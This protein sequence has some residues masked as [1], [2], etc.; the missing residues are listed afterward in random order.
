M[1]KYQ[2]LLGTILITQGAMASI[3][4]ISLKSCRLAQKSA[5]VIQNFH[6]NQGGGNNNPDSIQKHTH[7]F[8]I[9][10]YIRQESINNGSTISFVT[11]RDWTCIE[12]F[13]FAIKHDDIRRKMTLLTPQ[14]K[15]ISNPTELMYDSLYFNSLKDPF[16][17][18]SFFDIKEVKY[19]DD[20]NKVMINIHT[21]NPD[22][23]LPQK[24]LVTSVVNM[25]VLLN[26]QSVKLDEQFDRL[27]DNIIATQSNFH[28][29]I[30]TTDLLNEEIE[31]TMEY[32]DR[33]NTELKQEISKIKQEISEIKK[34]INL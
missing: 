13:R 32:I 10:T 11:T 16:F 8:R 24:T 30:I 33:I 31:S 14:K 1:K 17:L 9:P 3:E 22:F 7:G 34:A 15:V 29:K 18:A 6:I 25:G 19:P 2:Y 23:V 27:R 20:L 21:V 12:A 4:P 5:P 26:Y 28:D